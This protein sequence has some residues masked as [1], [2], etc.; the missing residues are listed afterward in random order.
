MLILFLPNCMV[1]SWCR[2]PETSSW[3]F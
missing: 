1:F 2:T 3:W